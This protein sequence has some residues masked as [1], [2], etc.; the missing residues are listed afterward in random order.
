MYIRKMRIEIARRRIVRVARARRRV[1]YFGRNCGQLLAGCDGRGGAFRVRVG[2]A[3]R[4]GQEK[5][6]AVQICTIRDAL[7]T[8]W[9]ALGTDAAVE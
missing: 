3:V 4:E 8:I 7:G 1:E 5:W 2:R 9:D 6:L